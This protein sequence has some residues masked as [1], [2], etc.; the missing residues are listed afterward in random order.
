MS[1]LI[2]KLGFVLRLRYLRYFTSVIRKIWFSFLGMK[3]GSETMLPKMTVTWPHQVKIGKAC[4]LEEHIQFKFDG[5]WKPGPSI[6]IGD[7]VFI[8]SNCEF[9]IRKGITIGDYSNIASSCHFIDHDHG[10][11]NGSLIG[12]QIGIEK[13]IIVGKDVWLGCNVIILKGVEINDG[14]IIGA[15]SVVT[16]SIPTNEIWAGIPAKKIGERSK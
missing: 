7:K 4:Q 5:I 14:V 1:K 3:V 10:K 16:K 15:G 13:E 2:Y 11:S 8:G 12:S 9:N 6:S